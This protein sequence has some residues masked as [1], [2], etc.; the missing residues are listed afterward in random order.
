MHGIPCDCRYAGVVFD[1][2]DYELRWPAGLLQSEAQALLAYTGPGWGNRVE[3]LLSEAF[4]GETPREEFRGASWADFPVALADPMAAFGPPGEQSAQRAF[5]RRLAREAPGLE[6]G[7]S[8]AP[9]WAARGGRSLATPPRRVDRTE[10]LY[11]E[12]TYLAED[13]A[14]RGY[15]QRAAAAP[16]VED[17]THPPS[18][19]EALAVAVEERLGATGLCPLDPRDWDDDT[20]YSLVEVVHDLVA[21]PRDRWWHDYSRCGRHYSAF[22]VAPGRA[23]YRWWVN[24]LFAR[25]DV[26]LELAADG[27]DAGRLVRSATDGRAELVDQ[28]LTGSPEIRDEV[29]HAVALWRGRSVTS[30]DK[31][32]AVVALAR[33]LE[34]RR[35]LLKREL[36]RKDEGVLFDLA[37]N[38]DLRHSNASQ[39]NDY[40]P[41]FL[42]WVFWW[43]LATVELTDRLLDRQAGR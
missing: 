7:R 14:G 9:Y 6:E 4:E 8:P 10:Q 17:E 33:V 26:G 25:F 29:A 28:T 23:L 43:Y 13:L 20:F 24:R 39:Q 30:A 19:H 27:E 15:L 38:F 37:N 32:S 41:V 34:Q 40:D 16:C 3:L 2:A 5:L 21:R 18:E 12:W 35:S 22:A 42:D 1:D 11:R 36:F 31:R